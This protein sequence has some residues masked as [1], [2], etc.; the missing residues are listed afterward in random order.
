MIDELRAGKLSIQEAGEK[1][2]YCTPYVQMLVHP[3][4]HSRALSKKARTDMRKWFDILFRLLQ[5]ESMTS[6]GLSLGVTKQ[7]ISYVAKTA[8]E[9]GFD[10]E[11]KRGRP[12]T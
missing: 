2:G 9:A 11:A 6:I 12:L 1:Y 8:N 5:G 3:R 10:I 7:C 4:V